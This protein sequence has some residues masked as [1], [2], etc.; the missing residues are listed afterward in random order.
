MKFA[1]FDAHTVVM[2]LVA[3]GVTGVVAIIVRNH[4]LAAALEFLFNT[5]WTGS[6]PLRQA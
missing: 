1:L 5:L 4:E 6:A 3:P 2:P